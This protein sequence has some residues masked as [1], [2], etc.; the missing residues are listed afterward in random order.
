MVAIIAG[1]S[2]F[3]ACNK[4]QNGDNLENKLK[5]E[6]EFIAMKNDGTLMQID[7][8][9]DKNSN[10]HFVTKNVTN[11]KDDG[12]CLII[13]EELIL[14]PRL[15]KNEDTIVIDIPNDAVYWLVP[16]ANQEPIKFAP[17]NNAK[18]SGSGTITIYCT[19]SEGTTLSNS[20]CYL[21]GFGS[22][23]KECKPK[24]ST[25]G[26]D[27]CR[28]NRVVFRNNTYTLIE[29]DSYLVKSNSVTVNGIT[30]E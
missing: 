5:Q 1:A 27:I 30:Y 19:C 26:C 24:N 28:T 8:F 12:L 29:E 21:D 11:K 3:Y 10:A 4:D 13:S 16:I 14:K 20:C 22:A 7:V 9:R 15:T 17:T 25:C 23:I 18:E 6:D 2:I